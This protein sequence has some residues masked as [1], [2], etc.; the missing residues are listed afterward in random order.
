MTVTWIMVAD[1]AQ[2]R[3][4]ETRDR[5]ERWQQVACFAN[6]DARAPGRQVAAQ[7]PVHVGKAM[8]STHGATEPP[9]CLRNTSAERFAHML[10]Q[11]LERCYRDGRFDHLVLVASPRFLVLLHAAID[12]RLASSI[13]GELPHDFTALRSDEIRTRVPRRLLA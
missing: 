5:G 3:T 6:P 12:D 1:P 9:A 7:R 2:A 13:S 8:R 4:F 10:G 11:A